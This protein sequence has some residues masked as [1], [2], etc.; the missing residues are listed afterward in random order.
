MLYPDRV[1]RWWIQEIPV[2]L[3]T[4]VSVVLDIDWVRLVM[5]VKVCIISSAT[6][7]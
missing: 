7:L 6:S 1:L 4:T 5:I 3:N 2:Q